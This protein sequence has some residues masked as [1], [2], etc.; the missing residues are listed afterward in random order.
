MGGIFSTPTSIV[1]GALSLLPDN[2]WILL[3]LSLAGLGIH[4]ANGQRPTNKFDQVEELIKS[5]DETLKHA[6]ENCMRDYTELVLITSRLYEAKCSVSKIKAR[7]LEPPSIRGITTYEEFVQYLQYFP[8][9]MWDIMQCG[10]KV[11]GIR[12]AILVS[13]MMSHLNTSFSASSKP[14]ANVNLLQGM[15]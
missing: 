15:R 5:V 14:N 12:T 1:L 11:E 10:K 6:K 3:A 9:I 8:K 7:M 13:R 4:I 2:R